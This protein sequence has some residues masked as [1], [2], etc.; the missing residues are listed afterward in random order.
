MTLDLP[1][2]IEADTDKIRTGSDDLDT[3]REDMLGQSEDTYTQMCVSAEKF[4]DLIAWDISSAST[5]E[6]MAWEETAKDLTHGAGL[7]RL[8]AEDIDRYLEER[9]VS[10]NGAREEKDGGRR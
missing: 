4:T 10:E 2:P 6:L 7:L 8:W 3:L 9:S 5:D 1:D